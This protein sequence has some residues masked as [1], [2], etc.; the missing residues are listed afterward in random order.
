VLDKK[1]EGWKVFYSALDGLSGNFVN[2]ILVQSG[3]VWTGTNGGIS[4]F[5]KVRKTWKTYS[6]K[7]GLSET[8]IKSLASVGQMIWAGG[9]GG[10][11]SEYDPALD[12][13]KRIEPSDPLKNGGIYSIAV[14]KEKVFVCRDNGVSIYDLPTRQWESLTI[15]DG[16]LSNTVFCSAED[17]NSIWFGTDKGASR[18]I[19]AP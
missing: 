13:W 12:R 3:F 18:L 9:I 1:T 8:E 16:L 15:A 11:L 5:D 7:E 2:S 10:T 17:K 6:Q 4:R 14:T 19:L